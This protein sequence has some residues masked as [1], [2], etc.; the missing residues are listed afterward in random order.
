MSE[1][2]RIEPDDCEVTLKSAQR[3]SEALGYEWD[4]DCVGSKELFFVDQDGKR[5][6]KPRY[7]ALDYHNYPAGKADE[8]VR[9]MAETSVSR[10]L[11]LP[12]E[13]RAV[14]A[15]RLGQLIFSLIREIWDLKQILSERT[16]SREPLLK[17]IDILTRDHDVAQRRIDQLET[18]NAQL[19]E[20][21]DVLRRGRDFE[22]QRRK[23]DAEL[24]GAVLGRSA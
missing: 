13:S 23:A 24:T 17:L 8:W 20:S 14:C 2:I 5:K 4:K 1:A 15:K 10:V 16:D 9:E 11:A 3:L 6:V 22:R 12:E 19:R 18:E 7:D 21:N